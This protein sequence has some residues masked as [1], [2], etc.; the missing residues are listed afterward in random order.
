MSEQIKKHM[1]QMN[2]DDSSDSD[3]IYQQIDFD[4][5]IPVE[6]STNK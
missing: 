6:E 5:L 3:Q 1:K 2:M 4:D